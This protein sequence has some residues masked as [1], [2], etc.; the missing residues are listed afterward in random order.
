MST[1]SPEQRQ[2]IEVNDHVAIDDGAFVV[3]KAEFCNRFRS[4]LET[5]ASSI[6]EQKSMISH[7]GKKVGWDDGCML[8]P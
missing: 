6:D 7:I 5:K 8:C 4:L 1:L 3:V 2:T